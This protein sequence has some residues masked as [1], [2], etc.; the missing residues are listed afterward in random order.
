MCICQKP[1]GL[2]VCIFS[3]TIL[4]SSIL[5]FVQQA[6]GCSCNWRGPFLVVFHDAPL[7]V[8]GKILRHNKG[9]QA[10]MDVLVL[11]TLRGGLLDSGLRIQMGDG[12]QCR[13]DMDN[14][15]IGSEWILALNGPGAKPGDGLALS[16]CGEYWLKVE[17]DMAFG[18]I[19]S[20][21]DAMKSVSLQ[22]LH[23]RMFYAK[24]NE[25]F[26]GRVESGSRF[27]RIFGQHFAFILQPL[28][29]G[30]EIVIQENGRDEN[31]A[32]LTPPLHGAPNPR[33]IEGW[34]LKDTSSSCIHPY[35][36]ETG[37]ANPRQFIF[38]PEVGRTIDAPDAGRSVIPSDIQA[39]ELFGHGTFAIEHFN[40]ADEN[41]CE[42]KILW[43]EFS[44]HVEGGY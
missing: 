27:S 8:R 4:F 10:T 19:D 18:S 20:T 23:L 25:T 12:M 3:L 39:V 15:P 32:R 36:A 40:L 16:H 28:D 41:T 42:P 29:T 38:S 11:E 5:L 31:I 17:N 14:F 22:N 34:H 21:Q 37:P 6:K 1:A 33:E 30:W 26:T 35:G 2:K 24:F 7:V 13:P 44:V 9:E 43:M